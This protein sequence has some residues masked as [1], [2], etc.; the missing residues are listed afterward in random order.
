MPSSVALSSKH[1]TWCQH[2]CGYHEETVSHYTMGGI[3]FCKSEFHTGADLLDPLDMEVFKVS[4]ISPPPIP[5]TPPL[6]TLIHVGFGGTSGY[7][8]VNNATTIQFNTIL[9]G[10]MFF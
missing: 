7:A 5:D 8:T 9:V 1:K 6:Q 4:L 3:C 10:G 2:Y